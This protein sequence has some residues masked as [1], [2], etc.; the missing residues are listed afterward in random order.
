[1][2]PRLYI[3]VTAAVM[4]SQDYTALTPAVARRHPRTINFRFRW[5]RRTSRDRARLEGRPRT[6]AQRPDSVGRVGTRTDVS[7]APA[8]DG[9]PVRQRGHRDRPRSVWTATTTTTTT[10]TAARDK[11]RLTAV[12]AWTRGTTSHRRRRRST[13]VAANNRRPGREWSAPPTRPQRTDIGK[14]A[15]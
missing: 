1:M 13:T 5:T 6:A 7:R 14:P 11:Q 12:K 10:T 9:V 4:R 3:Q 8:V 15:L 2:E